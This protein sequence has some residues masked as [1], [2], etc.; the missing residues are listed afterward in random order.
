MGR[1]LGIV[2][3]ALSV[4]I[5]ASLAVGPLLLISFGSV[6][7]VCLHGGVYAPFDRVVSLASITFIHKAYLSC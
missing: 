2:G 4:S 1:V 3:V 5:C 6:V 7:V